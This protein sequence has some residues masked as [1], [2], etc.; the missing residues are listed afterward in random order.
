MIGRLEP[1]L[2]SNRGER[3]ELTGLPHCVLLETVSTRSALMPGWSAWAARVP[4]YKREK[5]EPKNTRNWPVIR[6]TF[7][8]GPSS[9]LP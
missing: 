3:G 1:R 7:N 8:T 6:G 9:P 5:C 2:P 4:S